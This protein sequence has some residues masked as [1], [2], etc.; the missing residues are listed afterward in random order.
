MQL[1]ALFT[2]HELGT[3][4]KAQRQAIMVIE[5]CKRTI[6]FL[7]CIVVDNTKRKRLLLWAGEDDT[8]QTQALVGVEVD[9]LNKFE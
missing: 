1:H 4:Q 2:R 7:L 8:Q 5:I 6:V 3:S 9:D